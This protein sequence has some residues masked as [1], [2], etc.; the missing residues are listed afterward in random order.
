MLSWFP[1]VYLISRKQKT[2]S[3]APFVAEGPW[4]GIFASRSHRSARRTDAGVWWPIGLH[5]PDKT[6]CLPMI[7]LFVLSVTYAVLGNAIVCLVLI[8]R[9]VSL[10]FFLAGTP[11]YLYRVCAQAG[12]VVGTPLRR[13]AWTT[14]VAFALAAMLGLGLI[15]LAS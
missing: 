2:N 8:R 15:G 6:M 11:G 9:K 7:F 4:L 10:S 12:P 13:F 1:R 14:N 3:C 5:R